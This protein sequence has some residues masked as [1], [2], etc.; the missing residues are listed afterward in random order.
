MTFGIFKKKFGGS[1]FTF[2][3]LEGLLLRVDIV[4]VIGEY[5]KLRS[6]GANF[7]GIC[8]FHIEKS[9]S[10]TVSR[11]KRFFHCFGC[12]KHGSVIGFLM[13]REKISFDDAVRKLMLR[14]DK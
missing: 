3:Q 4:D 2:D 8:P 9:P 14:L 13:D 1:D 6:T 5:V 7:L 10:F 11:E 12:S